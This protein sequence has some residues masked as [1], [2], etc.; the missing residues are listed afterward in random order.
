MKQKPKPKTESEAVERAKAVTESTVNS[1]N[2]WKQIA[3]E[4]MMVAH[5]HPLGWQ[6]GVEMVKAVADLEEAYLAILDTMER[7]FEEID[8]WGKQPPISQN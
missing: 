6:H 7:H 8:S 3:Q 2:C 1:I 5:E 4:K